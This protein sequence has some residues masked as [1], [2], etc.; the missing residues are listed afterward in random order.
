M[1]PS[2][3]MQLLKN[4][5][6]RKKTSDAPSVEIGESVLLSNLE[7]GDSSKPESEVDNSIVK[8]N[9]IKTNGKKLLLE[10]ESFSF[11][12]V[13]SD[14]PDFDDDDGFKPLTF[15]ANVMS[16]EENSRNIY[17]EL[18]QSIMSIDCTK[19]PDHAY[20]ELD[21]MLL[22]MSEESSNELTNSQL[23]ILVSTMIVKLE[24]LNSYNYPELNLHEVKSKLDSDGKRAAT[25]SNFEQYFFTSFFTY[26][27]TIEL[28][29]FN[30]LKSVYNS[31]I[32]Q[33][34]NF[35]QKKGEM[36]MTLLKWLIN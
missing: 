32:E 2:D 17:E 14:V 4:Y 31:N 29:Q 19:G 35:Q 15:S 3:K 8:R 9:D 24:E 30:K 22:S 20:A 33:F 5:R 6:N 21:S 28:E 13:V 10:Q 26:Y 25:S 27:Q 16:E 34:S 1:N 7:G 12:T 11:E 18:K 36:L 23:L